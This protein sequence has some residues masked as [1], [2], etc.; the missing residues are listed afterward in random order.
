MLSGYEN[1]GWGIIKPCVLLVILVIKGCSSSLS[2]G[3]LKVMATLMTVLSMNLWPHSYNA[4]ATTLMMTY[5]QWRCWYKCCWR[6]LFMPVTH[7]FATFKHAGTIT[8][9]KIYS[10][11]TSLQWKVII[12]ITPTSHVLCQYTIIHFNIHVLF[13]EIPFHAMAP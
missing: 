3:C 5:H 8:C 12:S 2:S 4:T 11:G 10:Y 1:C 9:C 13:K 7:I 6:K